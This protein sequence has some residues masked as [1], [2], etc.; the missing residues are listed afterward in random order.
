M[1]FFDFIERKAKERRLSLSSRGKG[2]RQYHS[3]APFML[4]SLVVVMGGLTVV[5]GVLVVHGVRSLVLAIV[6]AAKLMI[7]IAVDVLV[8]VVGNNGVVVVVD[9][10][11]VS[12]ML[13][14]DV[15][16]LEVVLLVVGVVVHGLLVVHGVLVVHAGLLVVV[17]V[18]ELMGELVSD[19]VAEWLLV[20]VVVTITVVS[21]VSELVKGIAVESLMRGD[22]VVR[23]GAVSGKGVVRNCVLHLSAK[24]DLGK[25][26][27]DGVAELVEVLVLPLGLSI[28]DLVVDILSVH[29][30][31]VLDVEDEV[32]RIGES[33]GHLAKLIEVSAD[34]GLA[35]FELVGNVVNDVTEVLNGVEDGVE[36]SVLE[37]VNDT[38]EALPDV[39]G[40]AEALDTVRNLSLD[41]T[42][43]KT[44]KDLAHAEEGEVNVRGFHGLEVV[45]LLVLLVIDLVKELLPVVIEVVEELFV[46]DH[47]GLSVE[48]HS[49]G[50]AEVLTSIE[51]LAHAVVVETL[52]GV[53][54]NVDTVDDEGLGGLKEELLGVEEGLSHSL[55]LLVVVVVDLSAVVEHVTDVGDGETKL[56]NSL[57][58][59]LVGSVPEA[60]HGVLKMLLDGVGVRN[61]VANVGHAVEVEGTNEETFNDAS[62]FGV[63]VS[64]VGRSDSGDESG[65][66]SLEHCNLERKNLL[67]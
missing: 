61:A 35:L 43:E 30:E 56:V 62:N 6:V 31:V 29:D 49:G 60:A 25:G 27:T 23:D 21:V 39:L 15:G 53:L 59:L 33:L 20:V 11:G 1:C 4:C 10:A 13:E 24:E 42:S 46:V 63:V 32:P 16:S 3:I 51:P 52:T 38:A 9:G 44:L 8:L 7:V 47:L 58:D 26:E 19:F 55:D 66:E 67:L 54:E 41:G 57:G 65:S 50:L 5:V 40:I 14:L 45:H 64:V 17:V 28:H 34:G 36:G 48:E 2:R 18:V 37:L 22:I 12:L